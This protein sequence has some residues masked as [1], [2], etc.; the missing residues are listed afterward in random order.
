MTKLD[1]AKAALAKAKARATDAF[2]RREAEG[3]RV[4]ARHW[5]R[6]L[7]T[8]NAVAVAQAAVTTAELAV[9]GIAPMA[10][11]VMYG[12]KA[13]ALRIQHS[14]YVDMIRVRKDG[15]RHD[16]ALPVQTPWDMKRLH[17]TDRKMAK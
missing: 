3:R 11:I 16:G 12:G 13:Y 10:A 1:K 2:N 14:G 15:R 5:P 9:L 6:V 7:A 4:F 8:K 17:V